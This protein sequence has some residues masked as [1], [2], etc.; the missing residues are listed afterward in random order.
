MS[1]FTLRDRALIRGFAVPQPSGRKGRAATKLLDPPT[2][3]ISEVFA[4][5]CRLMSAYS[6]SR[7]H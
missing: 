1:S 5:T 7:I 2:R 3:Q 4:L 6:S